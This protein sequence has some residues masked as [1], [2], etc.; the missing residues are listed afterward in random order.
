MMQDAEQFCLG[1]HLHPG[2]KSLFNLGCRSMN[3]WA[4][5]KLSPNFHALNQRNEI[6]RMD[7]KWLGDPCE[8]TGEW[9]RPQVRQ[10]SLRMQAREAAGIETQLM[11]GGWSTWDVLFW[12]KSCSLISQALPSSGL[13]GTGCRGLRGGPF[14]RLVT[15][16]LEVST[17]GKPI[18]LTPPPFPAANIATGVKLGP[19]RL[20]STHACIMMPP[21]PTRL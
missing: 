12:E 1:M 14:G 9:N 15:G 2:R 16:Q 3:D 6:A 4:C 5:S 13:P 17:K 19:G 8:W 11:T 7:L 18:P 21:L 20:K 10:Q